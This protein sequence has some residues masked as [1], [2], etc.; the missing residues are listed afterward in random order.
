MAD[1][2]DWLAAPSQAAHTGAG[3]LYVTRE[4]IPP[5]TEAILRQLPPV[6]V[7]IIGSQRTVG[8]GVENRIRDLTPGRVVRIDGDSPFDIA[9]KLAQFFV[10]AGM[11]GWGRFKPAGDTFTFV[12][13]NDWVPAVVGA[14]TSHI[15]KHAPVIPIGTQGVPRVVRDYLLSV[16]PVLGHPPAPPFM[17]GLIIARPN[18]ISFEQ[19]VEL[20]SLLIKEAGQWPPP[21]SHP[22]QR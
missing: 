5:E 17:H 16:N 20:E 6:N 1:F 10:P 9:V 12:P 13:V 21:G 22:G 18:Q 4:S 14:L 11:F 15:G 3:I 7:Y 2:R 19:Q 8:R